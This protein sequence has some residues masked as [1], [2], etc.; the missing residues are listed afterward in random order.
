MGYNKFGR[1]KVYELYWGIIGELEKVYI[2]Y[3]I[4]F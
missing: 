1:E 2:I 3:F 4:V